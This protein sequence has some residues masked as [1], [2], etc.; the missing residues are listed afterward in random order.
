M[1][2]TDECLLAHSRFSCLQNLKYCEGMEPLNTHTHTQPKIFDI[3][4]LN[5]FKHQHVVHFPT[6]SISCW[7]GRFSRT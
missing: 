6:L 7:S 4:M 5:R 2:D 3:L 1:Q